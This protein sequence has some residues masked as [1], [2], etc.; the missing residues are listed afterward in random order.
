VQYS[1]EENGNISF[2]IIKNKAKS[3]KKRQRYPCS[4]AV[5]QSAVI[6]MKKKEVIH[7][8]KN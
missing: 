6:G 4:G 8:K 3:V 1:K 2:S 5:I 7:L